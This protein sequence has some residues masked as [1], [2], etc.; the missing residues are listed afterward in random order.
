MFVEEA[1]GMPVA[2]PLPPLPGFP[3]SVCPLPVWFSRGDRMTEAIFR[4]LTWG[5]PCESVCVKMF[6]AAKLTLDLLEDWSRM[7]NL[8]TGTEVDRSFDR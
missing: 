6:E 8:L 3:L 2:S 5:N 4:C 1:S 7:L